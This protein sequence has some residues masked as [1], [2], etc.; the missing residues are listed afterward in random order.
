MT[1]IRYLKGVKTKDTDQVL[2]NDLENKQ[3]QYFVCDIE[4]GFEVPTGDYEVLKWNGTAK[5]QEVLNMM[6]ITGAKDIGFRKVLMTNY[7]IDGDRIVVNAT[8]KIAK[9][10][11]IVFT[12]LVG[13]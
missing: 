1:A 3:G 11:R 12:M 2:S 10:T 4:L 9:G 13:Q 5:I 6:F 8:D 7:H